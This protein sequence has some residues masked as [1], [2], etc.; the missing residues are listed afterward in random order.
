M[1]A[2]I[3]VV[4]KGLVPELKDNVMASLELYRFRDNPRLSV[5]DVERLYKK[6][7]EDIREALIPFGYYDPRISA[8]LTTEKEE[9]FRAE[10][11]VEAGEPVRIA[12]VDLTVSG[13][14]K[15]NFADIALNFPL[16]EGDILDQ[17]KYEQG[18]RQLLITAMR[19]GYMKANFSTHQ[20]RVH[21]RERR[22]DVHLVL[23][24]G[25]RFV[26]GPTAFAGGTV[27]REL[28]ERYLPYQPGDPYRPGKLIELQKQLYRTE[29]FGRV[30]VEGQLEEAQDYAVPVDVRLTAPEHL[31]RYSAGVGYA[32]DTGARVRLEWWNRLLN[33]HG[34]QVRTS[35]QVSQYDNSLRIDYTIPWLDPK[36][37]TY[38]YSLGYQDQDWEDTSTKLVTVG[39]NLERKGELLR[40]GG[41]FQFRNE[42]YSVGST[43]G[44]SV[45]Y[46]P[47]YTGSLIWADNLFDTKYGLDLSLSV[48]GASTALASDVSYFK[49]VLGGKAIIT[50]FP[51][52]RLIGR[53]NL[54]NIL[55]DNIENLPPSLRFYAGG[56]QSVRGYAYR[57]L[58]TKDSSGA[59]VGGRYL[60]VGS[61][62][63]EKSITDTWSVAGFWDVGNAM[64]DLAIDLKQGVGGGV[65]YRLPFGQVRLDVASAISEPGMPLRL[66]ITVGADL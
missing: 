46:V 40:H 32:T 42:E 18:K 8:Q 58:G 22:A 45:V 37:D 2:D 36:R 54:G 66:H 6:A 63:L 12:R 38:G 27:N 16:K 50:L 23:A 64:D 59:V 10:F 33:T 7:D 15:E 11:T 39:V 1:A 60:V 31:N 44:S 9:Q 47:T 61:G 34:H 35:A 62:E 21:R 41:S 56:D 52:L 5:Y 55:V 14:G 65:R 20:L 57:Q 24:T 51:G 48:S 43:S 4:V 29:F 30:V 19:R 17:R 28:L 49:T 25:R 53:G 3:E 26:F 13:V